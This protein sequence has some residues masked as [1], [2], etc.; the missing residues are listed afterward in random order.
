VDVERYSSTFS[1]KIKLEIVA[2]D[3]P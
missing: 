1:E 2:I 3:G